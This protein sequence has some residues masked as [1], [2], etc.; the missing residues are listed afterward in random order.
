[1][2]WVNED[3]MKFIKNKLAVVI[4]ILS[5]AFLSLIAYSAN[6]GKMSFVENGV[7][8]TVNSVQ[9]LFYKGFYKIGDS[10]KFITNF[11]YIILLLLL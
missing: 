10:F 5:V 2:L 7:G 8:V 11:S 9:G 1:M 4:I 6:R 3:S